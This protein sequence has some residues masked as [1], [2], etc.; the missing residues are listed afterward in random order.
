MV[1]FIVKI[2]RTSRVE[3]FKGEEVPWFK[4]RLSLPTQLQDQGNIRGEDT[5][6]ISTPTL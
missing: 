1:G 3:C 5:K 4:E 6:P 2:H